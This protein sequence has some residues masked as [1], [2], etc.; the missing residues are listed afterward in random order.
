LQ[1]E[2][3]KKQG[4]LFLK[5]VTPMT[6]Q[7]TYQKTLRLDCELTDDQ[8]RD[9]A[10]FLKRMGFSDFRSKATDDAEAYGMQAASNQVADALREAGYAPR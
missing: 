8:A 4:S 10:Q 6:T 3:L 2:T 5:R 1:N 7:P 9:L